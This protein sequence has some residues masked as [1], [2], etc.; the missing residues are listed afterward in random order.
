[1]CR[2]SSFQIFWRYGDPSAVPLTRK[3]YIYTECCL[4]FGLGFLCDIE[5]LKDASVCVANV[6]Q[7]LVT[8]GSFTAEFLEQVDPPKFW[9]LK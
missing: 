5:C 7:V 1:M 9:A 8:L 6:C 4:R 3:G 2:G